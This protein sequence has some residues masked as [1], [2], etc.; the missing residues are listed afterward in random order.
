MPHHI[1]V[2]KSTLL[3]PLSD[4]V[5][6]QPNMH[7]KIARGFTTHR[8]YNMVYAKKYGLILT[9]SHKNPK[10]VKEV[11]PPFHE[12]KDH[13]SA[14]RGEGLMCQSLFLQLPVSSAFF[15]PQALLYL[16]FE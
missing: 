16:K 11:C 10:V 9:R 15:D 2:Q 8:A 13:C 12:A 3:A 4:P 7:R 1:S 5:A 14:G 6:P